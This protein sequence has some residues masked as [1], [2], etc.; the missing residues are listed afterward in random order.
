MK[1]LF[2]LLKMTRKKLK[3]MIKINECRGENYEEN[4][5]STYSRSY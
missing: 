4:Y 3:L 5:D 2:F 1:I